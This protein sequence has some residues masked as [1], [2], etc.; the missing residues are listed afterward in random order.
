MYLGVYS[1][2]DTACVRPLKDWPGVMRDHP[3]VQDKTDPLLSLL[4]NIYD[5][6]SGTTP[7]TEE[8]DADTARRNHESSRI[9]TLEEFD[10]P[11]LIVS[12]EAEHW[13]PG[14]RN[15]ED[16]GFARG[17]QV[18]QVSLILIDRYHHR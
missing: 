12:V 9:R 11:K 1:D 7:Q 14:T 3:D 8:Q 4:P 13:G 18:V 16:T 10:P 2:T 15:W 5:F 6:L 17:I